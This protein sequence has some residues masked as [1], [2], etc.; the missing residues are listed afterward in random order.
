MLRTDVALRFHGTTNELENMTTM[1]L[2]VLASSE[3]IEQP[4]PLGH[5]GAFVIDLRDM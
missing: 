4:V 1:L 3:G 2:R 5:R